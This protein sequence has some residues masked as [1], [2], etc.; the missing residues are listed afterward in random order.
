MAMTKGEVWY[1][2]Y[3]SLLS[4]MEDGRGGEQAEDIFCNDL[5]QSYRTNLQDFVHIPVF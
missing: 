1:L 2:L 4:T 5:L 3:A